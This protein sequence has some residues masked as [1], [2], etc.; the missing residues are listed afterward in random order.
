MKRPRG[1]NM[2]DKQ[3]QT[4]KKRLHKIAKISRDNHADVQEAQTVS[5]KTLAVE[6]QELETY[7]RQP[8][9]AQHSPSHQA[10]VTQKLQEIDSALKQEGELDP[11]YRL[12][13]NY[14]K[15]SRHLGFK[16]VKASRKK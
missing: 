15:G 1:K 5:S 7:I 10:E 14:R 16:A 6:K 9:F 2:P 8:A 11:A 3:R 12:N 4:H 13:P